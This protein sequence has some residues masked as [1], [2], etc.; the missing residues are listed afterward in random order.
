LELISLDVRRTKNPEH[1]LEQWLAGPLSPWDCLALRYE[2]V[3]YYLSGSPVI[4][5][6]AIFQQLEGQTTF[7]VTALDELLVDR[8][9]MLNHDCFDLGNFC[10]AY[11]FPMLSLDRPMRLEPVAIAKPWGREI[12]FTGIEQRG[13]SYVSDGVAR[14]PLPWILS[15]APRRL[16]AG[17]ERH[18]NLL[19]ILDPLPEEVY[20]DLYFELHEEKREVYVV[21]HI[22]CHAWPEG[23]G[24]IRFGFDPEV[25]GNYASDDDFRADFLAAV[26]RYEVVRREI[27]D[28]FDQRREV[29]G[30]DVN[31]PVPASCLQ[32][33]FDELPEHL[34]QQERQLREEM[35]RFTALLPLS[36]GDVVKVPLLTPHALQ[37]GVRTVEFQTPVYERRILSFAQ[38]VLTQGQWDTE[39]AV[40]MMSLETPDL[41]ELT[42]LEEGLGYLLVE[43]VTFDDFRVWR[44]TLLPG[45]GYLVPATGCYGLLMAI[46]GVVVLGGH[47]LLME[48]AV[49]LPAERTETLLINQS[50]EDAVVLIA[51]PT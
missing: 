15:A 13:Q 6:L 16:A 30:I 17:A 46:D 23:K 4:E 18:I 21:T 22:D 44:L 3:Q 24:A 27:D 5:L 26:K 32:G 7:T 33:W 8:L 35:N 38:K 39:Q 34:Q 29:L 41:P 37:H 31:V 45:S 49:L 14:S 25:K 40:A 43:V 19:K 2:Y 36:V 42:M 11:G 28:L 10:V 50:T 9:V 12:W 20:G 51:R 1:A 48:E 47:H